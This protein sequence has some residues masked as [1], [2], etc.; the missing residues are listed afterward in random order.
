MSEVQVIIHVR[1]APDGSV[2]AG[3]TLFVSNALA[4]MR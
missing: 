4:S 3:A 2:P 1:F